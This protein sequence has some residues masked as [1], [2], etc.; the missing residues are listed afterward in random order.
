MLLVQ[1]AILLLAVE[2]GVR[3]HQILLLDQLLH[4]GG[5]EVD[6]VLVERKEQVEQEAGAQVVAVQ[7]QQ[8]RLI[9]EVEVEALDQH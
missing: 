2:T 1:M 9:W 6:V 4:M 5:A 7:A 8:E 3:A